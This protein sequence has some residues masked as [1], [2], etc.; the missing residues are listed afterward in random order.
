MFGRYALPSDDLAGGASSVTASDEDTEY[1]A[2]NLI[3]PS[4]T[5]HLNLPSRPAKLSATS[6]S[7]TLEFSSAIAVIAAAVIYHNFDEGLD[8]TLEGGGGAFSIPMPIPAK[9]GGDDDDWTLSP[10]VAFGGTQTYDEWTLSVNEANSINPQVGRLLLLGALR[11]IETDVRCGVDEQEER[12]II[13][14]PTELGVETVT[15]MFNMRRRFA[16]EFGVRDAEVADLVALW[17]SARLRVL[18]WLLIPDEDINDAWFVR[19]D[20]PASS[21]TREN[22]N[23]SRIPYRVRELSRGLPWP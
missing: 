7:W 16:G 9:P 18:P 10:W 17:R 22:L 15:D 19:F 20:D 23:F 5:G 4:N 2:T 8:V 13:E 3:A 11:Q 1:P 21:R 14:Q 12:T 6:G